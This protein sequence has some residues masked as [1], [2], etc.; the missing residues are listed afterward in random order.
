[1]R[2]VGSGQSATP[3]KLEVHEH[4]FVRGPRSRRAGTHHFVH[5]HEGG[6]VP[7]QHPDTGPAR[8]T[9]DKDGWLRETGL[10]GGGRKKFTVRPTGEQFPRLELEPWQ[11]EF[12]IAA[13]PR[14]KTK[15]G[16]QVFEGPGIALPLRMIL[17][18]RMKVAAFRVIK[19]GAP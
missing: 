7:H 8:Y 5:S 1:M 19:G 10:R 16:E 6:D 12:E 14:V 15:P 13:Q 2:A 3:G 17:G 18:F 11:T 9:I 4:A